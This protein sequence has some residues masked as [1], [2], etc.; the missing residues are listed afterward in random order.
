MAAVDAAI[1]AIPDQL[2]RDSVRVEWDF[3]PYVERSH[4]ML[5][6]LASALG[7]SEEQVDQAFQQAAVL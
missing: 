5:M 4:P 7:L 3:A 6:P 1:E 2:E